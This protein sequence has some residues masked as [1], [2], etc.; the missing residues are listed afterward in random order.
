VGKARRL[1]KSLVY[2]V[3]AQSDTSSL[4]YIVSGKTD[5]N[6]NNIKKDR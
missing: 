6:N 5:N 1:R 2:L 3:E 4:P